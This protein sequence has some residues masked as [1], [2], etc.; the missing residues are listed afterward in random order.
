MQFISADRSIDIVFILTATSMHSD[1]AI[2]VTVSLISRGV[3]RPG[4]LTWG[5]SECQ[6]PDTE[7]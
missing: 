4:I 2:S 5:S 7:A 1:A 3:D 6:G